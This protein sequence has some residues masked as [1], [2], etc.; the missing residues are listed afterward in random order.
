MV[1]AI[2]SR[3]GGGVG[4]EEIVHPLNTKN[5]T[6]R[7]I[8]ANSGELFIEKYIKLEKAIR[9]RYKLPKSQSSIQFLIDSPGYEKYREGLDCCREIRN[10]YSHHEKVREIYPI[11][12]SEGM[13]DLLDE[14]YCL[15][16]TRPRCKSIAVPFSKIYCRTLYDSVSATLPVMREKTFT[17][18]PIMEG[19]K[20]VGIFDENSL[21][22]YLA[23]NGIVD[24]DDLVFSD[25]RDYIGIDDREMEVF[26]FHSTMTYLDEIKNEFKRQFDQGKRLGVAFL[27]AT[28][29]RNEDVFGMLT[30]WDII[31][32]P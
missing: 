23:D 20:V 28:G 6:E 17:H 32:M 22:C 26:T 21:F 15:V 27:T 30:A 29:N 4:E 7:R 8:M 5:T 14:V 24:L 11:I 18:V 10:V 1:D 31:G 3:E 19:R 25:L 2:V 9:L 12:P 13:L 16:T